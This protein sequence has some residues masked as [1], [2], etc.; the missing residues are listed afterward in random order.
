MGHPTQAD[1]RTAVPRVDLEGRWPL[2]RRSVSAGQ[3]EEDE[4]RSPEA[5]HLLVIQATEALAELGPGNGRDLVDHEAARLAQPVC[6]IRLDPQAEERGL[7]RIGGERTDGHGIGGVEAV[8]L[9]D[10]DRTGLPDVA[11]SGGSRP[12]LSAPQS[13]SRLRAS[14]NA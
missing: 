12:D 13:S 10:R 1:A 4:D 2:Q 5:D 11:A 9:D 8:V 7:G 6:V 14:M 3:S